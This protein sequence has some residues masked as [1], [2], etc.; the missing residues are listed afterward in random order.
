MRIRPK[1]A[2]VLVLAGL[3]VL[4]VASRSH[5]QVTFDPYQ[6]VAGVPRVV[7]GDLIAV[8]GR[9]V[10]LYG[11]DAPEVGQTCRT[12]RRETYDCGEVAKAMLER[13]IGPHEVECSVYSM[14]ASTE[15]M[16]GRCWAASRDL[17][18]AMVARGWAYRLQSLSDRYSGEQAL[19]QSR[20]RGVWAGTNQTPWAWR[21]AR[22]P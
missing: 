1:T 5:G 12:A 3:L 10:R 8:G 14:Q 21:G 20:R 7:E 11:I 17:G 9:L 13:L 19:A 22:R 16:V 4:A 18:G 2:A 15:I 6:E